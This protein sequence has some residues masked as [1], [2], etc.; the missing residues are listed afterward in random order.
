MIRTSMIYRSW[1]TSA[2]KKWP[3]T[4]WNRILLENSLILR[5]IL[6]FIEGFTHKNAIIFPGYPVVLF[7]WFFYW[8]YGYSNLN[9]RFLNH[10]NNN[11]LYI[12]ASNK[13]RAWIPTS[14][15]GKRLESTPICTVS[16]KRT[17]SKKCQLWHLIE[18]RN[19]ST[20]SND[21]WNERNEKVSRKSSRCLPLN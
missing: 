6:A 9:S 15:A 13:M 14:R 3:S 11:Q 21:G 12:K 19:F 8:L 10:S 16:D 7:I 2:Y 5:V 17:D 1:L 4:P 18:L 20:I